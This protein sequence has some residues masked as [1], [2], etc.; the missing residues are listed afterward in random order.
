MDDLVPILYILAPALLI[1]AII[2]A[3]YRNRGTSAATD[4]KAEQGARDL[5]KDIETDRHGNMD[6]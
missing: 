5:R 4:R 2:W 3:W 1:A 6:L